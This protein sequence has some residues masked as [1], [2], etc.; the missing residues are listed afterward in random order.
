[1]KRFR[2]IFIVGS[3]VQLFLLSVTLT[4]IYRHQSSII[5]N[6]S[7]D[8]VYEFVEIEPE[9]YPEGWVVEIN[10]RLPEEDRF[11]LSFTDSTVSINRSEFLPYRI[12]QNII[13]PSII[14]HKK[15]DIIKKTR[16]T[17]YGEVARIAVNEWDTLPLRV[18]GEIIKV[19]QLHYRRLLPKT[20][21]HFDSILFMSG[22]C[23]GY[24]PVFSMMIHSNGRVF[25]RGES[26]TE[27]QGYYS[28]V[29]SESQSKSILSKFQQVD[30]ENIDSNY[31]VGADAHS[32]HLVV[33][34]EGKKHNVSVMFDYEPMELNI[35]LHYFMELH[36]WIDLEKVLPFDIPSPLPSELIP[37]P[38]LK[39]TP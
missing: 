34:N 39:Y 11:F 16:M 23:Y 7:G 33:Y 22:G 29:L 36:K 27:K 3:V 5:R 14:I 18:I 15:E 2:K 35:L 37:L 26:F 20:N 25:F 12:E 17:R 28:G 9:N 4:T 32:R 6:I 1:M 19:D 21:T 8:W 24:C 10:L 38:I 30:F 31:G 13:N